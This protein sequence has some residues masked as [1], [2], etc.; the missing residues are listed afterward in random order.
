[1]PASSK[2][3]RACSSRYCSGSVPISRSRAPVCPVDLRPGPQERGQPLARV[4]PPDEDDV[5]E[6]RLRLGVIGDQDSVRNDAVVAGMPARGRLRGHRRHGDPGVDPVDQEAPE[7]TAGAEP[8]ELSVGVPGGDQRAAGER[9]CGHADRGRHRLVQV[10]DVELLLDEGAPYAIDR[11][12][13]EDDV[14]QRP[15][16]RHDDRAADGDDPVGQLAVSARA[17]MQKPCEPA[18]R[19]VAHQDLHV[20]TPPP[21]RGRLVLRV[22]DDT[23]PVRPRERDDDADL[24]AWAPARQ[25]A[26]RSAASSIA[27]SVTA[28]ESRTQPAPLGPKPSPGAT[29]TRSSSSSRSAVKPFGQ[30]QPDVERALADDRYRKRSGES[31]PA[32][33]IR[34][35]ALGD[36]VLRPF[37][38][39]DSR[40]LQRREDPDAAV[41]VEQVD[42]LDHL[43]VADDEADPPAGHAVGLRHRPH[44]DADVLRARRREEALGPAAVEDEVDVRGVVDD[45]TTR[46][47]G[48]ANRCLERAGRSA[49]RARIRRV[50]EVE[51][52]RRGRR[53]QV[54]RPA[55]VGLERHR[56]QPSARER[57]TRGVVGVVRVGQQNRVAV[58]GERQRELDD[59]RLRAGD[60]RDLPFRVELDAVDVAVAAAIAS[61]VSR[62]PRIGE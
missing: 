29:A 51:R 38:R 27:A 59:R 26:S 47:V 4:V 11:T 31:V 52:R 44:L 33:L 7:V 13:R 21:E 46:A 20:V 14:R 57:E 24:H 6:P 60:E 49:D 17:G 23:A 18:G 55:G 54:R 8:L 61:F 19:I 35:D 58:V 1:M 53:I 32:R 42:A 34:R 43:R 22:L 45:G 41:V 40:R 48:P 12:R 56:L 2:R 30:P 28:S 62:R 3:I 10:E 36:R 37:E 25:R 39:R 15:V 9:E 50:V 5:I 16:R